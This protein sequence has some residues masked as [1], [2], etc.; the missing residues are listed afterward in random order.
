MHQ[1]DFDGFKHRA[2]RE[3]QR[4]LLFS[5]G[6]GCGMIIVGCGILLALGMGGN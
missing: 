6:F 4:I 3:N 5:I 2:R 1:P